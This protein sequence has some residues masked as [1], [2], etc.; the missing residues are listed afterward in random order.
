MLAFILACLVFLVIG[1]L[2]T[3]WP[4]RVRDF[5]RDACIHGRWGFWIGRTI[6]LRR[7]ESPAYLLEL[8]V[9]GVVCI[10]AAVIC[11]WIVF[12]EKKPLP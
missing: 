2:L 6:I 5:I 8:R 12:G 10:L 4:K 11:A 3:V 9:I 1:G 7:V